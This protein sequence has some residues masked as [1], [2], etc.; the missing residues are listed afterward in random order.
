MKK[1]GEG[2][3]ALVGALVLTFLFFYNRDS[4]QLFGWLGLQGN[5]LPFTGWEGYVVTN[6]AFLLWIPLLIVSFFGHGELSQYG[7]AR[8]DGK[9]GAM[10]AFAMI[11]AMAPLVWFASARPEFQNYYPLDRRI[12]TSASYAIYF[13]LLYGYYLFC[14]E[15]FFRGFLTFGLYRWIGSWG[16]VVQACAFGLMHVG[17]PVPEMLGSFIAGLILGW[18]AIRVKSF[19]PCFWAHWAISMMMDLMMIYRHQGT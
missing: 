14:W 8:G 12:L 9:N 13:E 10:M 16:I 1:L 6:T 19:L 11:A 2:W 5:E 4:T 17:K 18:V 15:F 3:V 7:L